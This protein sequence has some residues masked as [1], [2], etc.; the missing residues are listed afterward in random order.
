MGGLFGRI[1]SSCLFRPT[2]YSQF[3][4]LN[5]EQGYAILWRALLFGGFSLTVGHCACMF[6]QGGPGLFAGELRSSRA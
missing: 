1:C 5:I 3:L 4:G 2:L 6:G